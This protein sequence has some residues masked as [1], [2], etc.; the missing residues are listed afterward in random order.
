MAIPVWAVVPVGVGVWALFNWLAKTDTRA[1]H[2]LRESDHDA[3][4]MAV[5]RKERE[6]AELRNAE[7]YRREK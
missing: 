2:M 6:L 3:W 4:Q 1:G 5:Q 7:P